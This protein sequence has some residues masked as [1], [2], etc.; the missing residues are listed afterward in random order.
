MKERFQ[1]SKID[2]PNKN[3]IKEEVPAKKELVIP[4][5]LSSKSPSPTEQV[6][7]PK[8]NSKLN[9]AQDTTPVVKSD[10]PLN[11]RANKKVLFG[12]LKI[13]KRHAKR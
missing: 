1:D 3:A 10:A 11:Q 9:P 4:D 7:K 6:W 12:G 5:T 2:Y 13:T 8:V